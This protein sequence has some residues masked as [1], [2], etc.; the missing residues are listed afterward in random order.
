MPKEG[1]E[2]LTCQDILSYEEIVRAAE[3]MAL[4]GVR[5]IKITGGEPLVRRQAA[6]LIKQLKACL[7]Y[8]SRFFDSGAGAGKCV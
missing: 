7:L 6:E 5:K 1:V 8:T 3:V 4:L 2:Q